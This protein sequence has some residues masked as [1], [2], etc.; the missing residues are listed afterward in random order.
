MGKVLVMNAGLPWE[1]DLATDWVRNSDS[2]RQTCRLIEGTLQLEV[3]QYPHQIRAAAA[4]VILLCRPGL[5][6]TNNTDEELM[7]EELDRVCN[8]AHRKLSAIR[9]MFESK[10]KS[11]PKLSTRPEIRN[12]LDSI[13]QEQRILES[14]MSETPSR[15][16]QEPPCSWGTFW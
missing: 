15:L 12:L 5:W 8:L 2:M 13:L 6:A 4:M 7:L 10:S 1:N 9:Q 11:N 14:R 16:P 3:T